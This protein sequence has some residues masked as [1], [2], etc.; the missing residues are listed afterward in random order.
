MMVART[1]VEAIELGRH[2]QVLGPFSGAQK[3]CR[4][5]RYGVQKGSIVSTRHLA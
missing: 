4:H 3:I 1:R 2:D 5:T